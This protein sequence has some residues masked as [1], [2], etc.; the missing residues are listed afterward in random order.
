MIKLQIKNLF[1]LLLILNNS[2]VFDKHS[3]KT[4]QKEVS[5]ATNYYNDALAL[6]KKRKYNQAIE[7]F[8]QATKSNPYLIEAY[9]KWAYIYTKFRDKEEARKIVQKG[10]KHN[11]NNYRLHYLLLSTSPYPYTDKEEIYEKL[12]SLSPSSCLAYFEYAQF[13]EER[14][15]DKSITI[16]NQGVKLLLTTC[17]INTSNIYGAGIIRDIIKFYDRIIAKHKNDTKTYNALITIQKAVKT[18]FKYFKL[19]SSIKIE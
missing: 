14:K 2:C 19:Q 10:I 17:K 11:P 1:I 18:R 13:L 8:D 16:M 4:T 7:K 5:I 9:I 3:K 6:V 15:L 12:I